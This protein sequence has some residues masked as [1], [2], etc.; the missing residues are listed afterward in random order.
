MSGHSL[1]ARQQFR[2]QARSPSYLSLLQPVPCTPHSVH[3]IKE[4]Y[5]ISSCIL[6]ILLDCTLYPL[7]PATISQ[8]SVP[9]NTSG[10]AS[11]TIS[12]SCP[13]VGS[14]NK[15]VPC[16]RRNMEIK[17]S[18]VVITGSSVS[19]SISTVQCHGCQNDDHRI[20]SRDWPGSCRTS[21]DKG[22]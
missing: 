8:S 2:K 14:G 9:L 13:I 19:T 4:M 16:L 6:C 10:G 21:S 22:R 3:L 17:G 7:Y 12:Y 15:F 11:W 5:L 1:P 18:V 20:G